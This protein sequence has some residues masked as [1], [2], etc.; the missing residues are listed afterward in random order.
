VR[1]RFFFPSK[2]FKGE[3]KMK[4]LIAIL[5]IVH[6]L[7]VAGQSS[8]S[9]NPIGGI[10]NPAW[11]SWWPAS[12]GQSWLLTTLGIERS[13]VARAGGFLWLVAGAVLVAAGLGVL[14]LGVPPTWWRSL[15]L[16][17]AA[18]SLIMLAIY[19]HPFLSI[20]I[21][22]SIVLLATLVWEQWPLLERLGL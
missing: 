19:L 9:F 3:N 4:I 5:L 10:K 6:G 11:L 16:S 7:I 2:T 14:G 8:G 21:G 20:G 17:G 13:L 18:I 15:A 22:A 1:I 12:L